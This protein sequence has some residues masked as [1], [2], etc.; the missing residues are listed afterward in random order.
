MSYTAALTAR[1]D[2]ADAYNNMGGLLTELGRLDDAKAALHRA[3]ELNPRLIG[4]YVNLGKC[5]TFT[6]EDPHLAAM[7]TLERAMGLSKTDRM[8]LHFALA[9]AYAD[10]K[11]HNRAFENLS[12]GNALKREQITYDEAA[13]LRLFKSTEATFTRDLVA[14]KA[15]FGDPSAVPIFILGMPRSGTTLVEQILASHRDVHGG[16]EHET[17]I[18]LV[19]TVRGPEGTVAPPYPDFVASAADEVFGEMGARYVAE[20]RRFA[21][22]AGRVTD[23][24]PQNF[25]LAGLIHLALP[26]ARIIHVIRDPVDTCISCF[27]ML[28]TAGQHH[29]YNLAELGRYH[30]H[31]QTLMAHWHN[32]LP[33]GRIFDVRYEDIVN[34]LENE[35]RRILAHCDL[36]WDPNCLEFHQ[37]QRPVH[38]ASARQVR[39]PIYNSAIG[40]GRVYEPYLGP[41]L[42]ELN[43]AAV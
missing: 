35:A 33:Q 17:L 36:D 42:A 3:L 7:Q 15:G 12:R 16:G 32:V 28:F 26:N 19:R 37:N 10:I 39:Q 6:A 20:L 31:Y 14:A 40:R 38:T 21:P 11:D 4:A 34:D 2:Y 30:R 1:P 8:R 5:K 23:K 9:K 22:D 13:T 29:T 41:L 24:V 25:F 43:L 27:S 18:G